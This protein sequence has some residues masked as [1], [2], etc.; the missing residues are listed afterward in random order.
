MKTRLFSLSLVLLLAGK[1]R[2]THKSRF[3]P[4]GRATS[5]R[6]LGQRVTPCKIAP[7]THEL[8]LL[9]VPTPASSVS[10]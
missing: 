8:S 2:Q 7:S 5:A 1:E 3:L 9:A 6:L 10:C 4:V